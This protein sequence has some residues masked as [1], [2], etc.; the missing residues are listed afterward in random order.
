MW[1][2]LVPRP[3][4]WILR[5]STARHVVKRPGRGPPHLVHR[6]APKLGMKHDTDNLEPYLRVIITNT[7]IIT[8]P[9]YRTKIIWGRLGM[10]CY[11]NSHKSSMY[12]LSLHSFEFISKI[13]L[14]SKSLILVS[15]T[16]IQLCFGLTL[17]LTFPSLPF[18]ILQVSLP[19]WVTDSI[20]HYFSCDWYSI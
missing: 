4:F 12:I 18:A 15:T 8:K 20:V 13:S 17:P 6:L 9:L 1:V 14:I 2:G 16:L 5:H 7:T 11:E 10:N 3:S 19:V